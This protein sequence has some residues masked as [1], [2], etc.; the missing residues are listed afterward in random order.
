MKVVESN[1]Q[2]LLNMKGK[3]IDE[4]KNTFKLDTKK[5]IKTV[6]KAQNVFIFKLQEK[7]NSIFVKVDGNLLCTQSEN[8]IKNIKKTRLKKL[9]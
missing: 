1:N 6:S 4:T 7:D 2:S 5:G 3:I 8:R 9:N